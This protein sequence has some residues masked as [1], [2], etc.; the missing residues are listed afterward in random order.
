MVPTTAI[1]KAA[2]EALAARLT[3]AEVREVTVIP[4]RL[5]P[6]ETA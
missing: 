1:G 5:V 6:G 2:A 3:G 4:T